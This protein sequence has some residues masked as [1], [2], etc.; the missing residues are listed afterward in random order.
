RGGTFFPQT[1]FL[2]FT[3]RRLHG[4]ACGVVVLLRWDTP[5]CGVGRGGGQ[6]SPI[7]TLVVDEMPGVFVVLF[8]V[9]P[10]RLFLRSAGHSHDGPTAED[11]SAEA[12]R[13]R[14]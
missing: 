11:L 2:S 8:F 10:D 14:T 12:R 6:T 7:G 9:F 13:T 1:A 4:H 5:Q 3:A